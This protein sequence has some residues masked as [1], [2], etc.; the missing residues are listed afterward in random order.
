MWMGACVDGGGGDGP[1]L[2]R[3]GRVGV[4]AGKGRGVA[5]AKMVSRRVK[6]DVTRSE[7]GADDAEA[8]AEAKKGLE[9]HIAEVG[10]QRSRT[11]CPTLIQYCS[12]GGRW[13]RLADFCCIVAEP[14]VLPSGVRR[15][16]RCTCRTQR[17]VP[18]GKARSKTVKTRHA[19]LSRY[20]SL[21][22]G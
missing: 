21:N 8:E 7:V 9:G 17:A 2:T 22:D 6:P 18:L 5:A 3:W 16:V 14:S 4:G 11:T 13:Q 19:V 12:I 20:H 10:S 1:E 15:A